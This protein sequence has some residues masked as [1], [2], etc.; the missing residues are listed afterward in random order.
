[1]L[2]RNARRVAVKPVKPLPPVR[3]VRQDGGMPAWPRESGQQARQKCLVNPWG[4]WHMGK[5]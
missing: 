1:M 5:P 3:T 2:G 4:P